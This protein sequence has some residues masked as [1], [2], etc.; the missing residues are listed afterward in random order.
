MMYLFEILR[1][2]ENRARFIECIF[3][4]VIFFVLTAVLYF[5]LTIGDHMASLGHK[6]DTTNGLLLADNTDYNV[7]VVRIPCKDE[8]AN[9]E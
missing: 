5:V 1:D 8:E 7:T 2:P 4:L 3:V 6:L 9:N